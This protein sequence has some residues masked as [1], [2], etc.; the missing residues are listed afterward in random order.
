[1][2]G[3]Q[4]PVS[5]VITKADVLKLFCTQ[6]TILAFISVQYS[7]NYMRYAISSVQSLTHV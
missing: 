2:A 7:I 1:M 5:H 4:L 3:S 6:T